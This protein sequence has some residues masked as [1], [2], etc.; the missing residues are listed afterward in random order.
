MLCQA[1]LGLNYGLEID[2]YKFVGEI[3]TFESVLS[4]PISAEIRNIESKG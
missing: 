3:W 1:I 2:K 4:L